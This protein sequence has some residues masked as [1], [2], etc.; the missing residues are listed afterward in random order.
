M[1]KL[2]DHV[3]FLSQ[4]IGPR[5]AGTEE[6]QQ[7]A[8]Y[9]AEQ[10]Q[11]EANLTASI[12]DFTSM[13]NAKLPWAI[14][15]F[16]TVLLGALSI[17]LPV[18]GIPAVIGTL[19]MAV[20]VVLEVIDRP[21]LSRLMSRGVSQN[22]VARYEPS[23]AAS[24]NTSRRRK[25]I[26]VAR[27][28][29]GKTSAEYKSGFI[30]ILPILY[31]V[32][33]GG[34]ILV[35]IVLLIKTVFF[36]HAV[37]AT[38][39]VLNVLLVIGLV[40]A[41]IPVVFALLN[42]FASYNEAANSNASGVAVLLDVAERLGKGVPAGY[43]D[44]SGYAGAT[45]HG[46]QEARAQGVVPAG[47]DLVY[48]AG[49]GAAGHEGEDRLSAA[50]AAVAALSGRPV[51][52]S[53][54][55]AIADN[56]VQV[57]DEPIETPSVEDYQ[58]ERR[59]TRDALTGGFA[60]DMGEQPVDA[61]AMP[62]EAPGVAVAAAAPVPM[63]APA[64]TPSNAGVPD[65]FKKGQEQAK[66][67]EGASK[68]NVQRSRYADA[69]DAA[70]SDSASNFAQA[71]NVVNNQ[72]EEQLQRMRD[73]IMEV[74][75]PQAQRVEEAAPQGES[76]KTESSKTPV[77]RGATQSQPLRERKERELQE[78]AQLEQA[79]REQAQQAGQTQ[80]H[81]AIAG[82][83][84]AP[85]AAQPA[86]D[87]LGATTAM[88]PINIDDL[89]AEQLEAGKAEEAPAANKIVDLPPVDRTPRKPIKLPDIGAT[90]SLNA[91]SI[92]SMKQRAPLA[93]AEESAT[94][95]A[96]SL[97]TMLPSIDVGEG[98][99]A[100]DQQPSDGDAPRVPAIDAG[101]GAVENASALDATLPTPGPGA[102]GSFAP[103]G[104]T[105]SF[106]PVSD[107]LIENA[108]PDELY[109]D[110]ADD[111]VYDEGFTETGAF[112]G[113]G[114]VDM[115]KSRVRRFFDRFGSKKKNSDETSAHEWLDV[116]EDFE[117]Q[118][119]GAA[120]GGW[121]SFRQEDDEFVDEDEFSDYSDNDDRKW[122]GGAFSLRRNKSDRGRD[123]DQDSFVDEIDEASP[124]YVE[125]P[126]PARE[127]SF[128]PQS[129]DAVREQE[130]ESVYQFRYGSIDTEVWLVA[131]GSELSNNAGMRAFVAE[132]EQELRGAVVINLEALGAGELSYID[133]EGLFKQVTA[134]SRM[135]RYVR[136]ASQALGISVPTDKMVWR[137]SSA[138][139]A[140]K[141][142]VQAMSLV[143]V[144][145]G[146]PAYF[147]EQ[148]DV[149][150]NV[151]EK[152]L[153]QNSNFV[154]EIL[155]NI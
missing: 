146:K 57:K 19:L 154:M 72:V 6:E 91:P 63:P 4:E 42:Q 103:A 53:H 102:T 133:K 69:L 70:L 150:D 27:Y 104:A 29:S 9:I 5:P 148:D 96:K 107:E 93:Q 115:P 105:G 128:A 1:T 10:I 117:A 67:S 123:D 59:E 56:L 85:M 134:S 43:A 110:D 124:E 36:P 50:K 24:S 75:A 145:N 143:G 130:R 45:I 30:R 142:G 126:Q 81:S 74:Q 109:I 86:A 111:S 73:G 114:Y 54:D 34:M 79:Q 94:D 51:S 8:L 113:P 48:E 7:A 18:M 38:A 15:G 64:P 127:Q 151:D 80:P 138:A 120:R 52:S 153:E 11:K 149:L 61:A 95:A 60:Q 121:E 39:I 83:G 35:P 3:A 44:A 28:D 68:G 16:I 135:K 32:I 99:A 84:A 87:D 118:S 106:A 49:N 21:V 20:L 82:A 92:E 119:A 136:K 22:I 14:C 131:L 23:A 100:A 12:E 98:E 77:R 17:F 65:W 66:K 76:P 101:A 129:E 25:V 152:L 90:G 116:D 47:A 41:F 112:A 122:Q 155:R 13:S 33:L 139:Y 46:E 71:N 132:H 141:K 40:A 89:K 147:A 97:L 58:E 137:D 26:L 31:K 88:K 140:S 55:F 62:Q 78:Q 2:T 125:T 37:G 144:E 108:D